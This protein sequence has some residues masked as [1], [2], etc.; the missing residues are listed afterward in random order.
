MKYLI[1]AA[2][3]LLTSTSFTF[4]QNGEK[5]KMQWQWN[6]PTMDEL[7]I[8][9]ETQTK[10]EAVK[11]ANDAEVKKIKDDTSLA[12]DQRKK[13]MQEL[14]KKRMAEIDALLTPE[15]KAKADEKRKALKA[16][17]ETADN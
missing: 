9:S 5:K 17:V 6:K 14:R 1:I 15:Q 13:K 10:I 7:D 12:D 3:L 2:C 8:N 11:T 16:K 4:A